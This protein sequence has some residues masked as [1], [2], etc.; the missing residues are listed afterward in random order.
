M[1]SLVDS[2]HYVPSAIYNAGDGILIGPNFNSLFDGWQLLRC[3]RFA[4]LDEWLWFGKDG[5]AFLSM[6]HKCCQQFVF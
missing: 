4:Y 5:L 2:D 6:L 3:Q 1:A